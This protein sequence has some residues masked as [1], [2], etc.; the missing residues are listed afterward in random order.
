MNSEIEL[1]RFFFV[2][3]TAGAAIV[4]LGLT[5]AI[6]GHTFLNPTNMAEEIREL[7]TNYRTSP[8]TGYIMYRP[9]SVFVSTGRFGDFLLV[10][11]L[12]VFGFSSYLLLRH[13]RGRAFAFVLI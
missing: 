3:L 4:V 11:W 13:K 10:T 12:L 8:L 2:N 7:S 6:L 1:R 9:T 5:Q